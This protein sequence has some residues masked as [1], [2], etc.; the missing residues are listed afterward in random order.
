MLAILSG[1]KIIEI[2][3]MRLSKGSLFL[4]P[5]LYLPILIASYLRYYRN[6]HKHMEVPK[7]HKADV[8]KQQLYMNISPRNMLNKHTFI[9]FEKEKE[10][11]DVDFRYED[12]IKPFEKE[13]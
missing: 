7:M 3:Y 9:I 13:T 1:F 10:L 2:K 8:Y 12:T 5:F 11:N 6:V 4:F